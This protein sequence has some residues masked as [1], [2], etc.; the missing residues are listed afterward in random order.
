MVL[1]FGGIDDFYVLS[2]RRRQVLEVQIVLLLRK[3]NGKVFLET[4][5]EGDIL[6]KTHL[7]NVKLLLQYLLCYTGGPIDFPT[8]EWRTLYK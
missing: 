3:C 2:Q 7:I 6:V 1:C 4:C 8:K 5:A